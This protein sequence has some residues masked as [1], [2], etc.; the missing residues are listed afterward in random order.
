MFTSYRLSPFELLGLV[1]TL[2]MLTR[3]QTFCQENPSQVN[4]LCSEL[5]NVF[6][7]S[8]LLELETY[9]YRV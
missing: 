8:K 5:A 9:G 2:S 6:Q 3:D 4:L 1:T 7:L